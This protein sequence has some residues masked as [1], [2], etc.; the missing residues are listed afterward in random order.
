MPHVRLFCSRLRRFQT[1]DGEYEHESNARHGGK[2]PDV[3]FTEQVQCC[4]NHKRTGD[5][6]GMMDLVGSAAIF[7]D[8]MSISYFQFNI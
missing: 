8:T 4:K 7:A 5:A 2:R 6:T 1:H 3:P